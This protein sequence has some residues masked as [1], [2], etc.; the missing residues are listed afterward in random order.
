MRTVMLGAT[1][2]EVTPLAYGT[3]QFGGD[4]GPV[5]EQAA[6]EAIQ[7]AR[8]LP[9]VAIRSGNLHDH[10]HEGQAGPE[11]AAASESPHPLA[12]AGIHPNPAA[13]GLP[14]EPGPCSTATQKGASTMSTS[15]I[16]TATGSGFRAAPAQKQAA[17]RSAPSRPTRGHR[18]TPARKPRHRLVRGQWRS[19]QAQTAPRAV[20]RSAGQSSP[21]SA[22]HRALAPNPGHVTAA[23]TA[24]C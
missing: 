16:A 5:D 19:G 22:P 11:P 7:H 3:W 1:G 13:R 21:P 15:T 8:S 10:Q 17:T 6:T 2:L 14:G 23:E 20:P 18:S 12:L 24:P 4:W 9:I